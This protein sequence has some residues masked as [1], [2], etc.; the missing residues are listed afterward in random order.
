[1]SIQLPRNSR[2]P[3]TCNCLQK[4]PVYRFYRVGD[5]PNSE[6]RTT[7][8]KHDVVSEAADTV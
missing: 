6:N 5:L 8:C 1:M 7:P 4:E 2:A 3:T